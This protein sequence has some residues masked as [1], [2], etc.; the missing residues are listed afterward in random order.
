MMRPRAPMVPMP[1][2]LIAHTQWLSRLARALVGDAAALDVVQQ[3]Y[4]VALARPPL[5][6]GPL[7]PWLAGVARKIAAM[8]T[9]SRVRRERRE[10]RD[11]P[12]APAV[13]TPEELVMR[14]EM[15]EQ[16]AR[17]VL[18]LPELLRRTLLLRY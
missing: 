2:E 12:A 6:E 5:R 8:T 3:T 17:I 15:H 1:D 4:E 11:E 18:E 16:V 10:L 7:G 9:R 14:A 13:P